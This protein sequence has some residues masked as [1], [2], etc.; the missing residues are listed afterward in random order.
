MHRL[1]V[2][3][4]I[5]IIS[6]VTYVV[7]YLL[8]GPGWDRFELWLL[9]S[10]DPTR[11]TRLI[12]ALEASLPAGTPADEVV[13]ILEQHGLRVFNHQQTGSI[14]GTSEWVKV[15]PVMRRKCFAHVSLDSQGRLASLKV[16]PEYWAPVP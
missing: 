8:L 15:G 6:I 7:I 12:Q 4:R 10:D 1:P 16:E 13:Q 3:L 14:N 5:V 9:S 11:C 2:P